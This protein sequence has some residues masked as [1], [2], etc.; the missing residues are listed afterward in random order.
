MEKVYKSLVAGWY[1][2]TCVVMLVAFLASLY[3]CYKSTWI[4]LIDMVFV[5]FCVYMMFDMWFHTDYTIKGDRLL[6]RCGFLFRM[7]LPIRKIIEI[8]DKS[9]ILSSPALSAKRIGLPQCALLKHLSQRERQ[10]R[11]CVFASSWAEIA[12]ACCLIPP[13]TEQRNDCHWQS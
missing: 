2:C 7:E 13:A 12:T 10:V 8:T 6:I 9:T 1:K 4:L 11:C 3:L 5:G